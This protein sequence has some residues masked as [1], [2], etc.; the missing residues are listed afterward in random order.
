MS[1]L[2]DQAVRNNALFLGVTETWLH[3]GVLDAEVTYSFPG[4]NILRCDRAGGRQGGGVALYLRDDLTGDIL[5]SY[6]Q[7][8][9]LRGGSV[10]E[11][12]VVKIHQLDTIV[13]VVYRPPDTRCEEF[14]GV[15]QCL[16]RTLSTLPAPSPSILVM[17]DMNFPRSCISWNHSEEEGLLAPLVANHREGETAGGKQ[18]RLQAQQLIDLASKYSLQQEVNTPTHAV[19]ILDLVFSNNCELLT[20]VVSE[21]WDKFSDHNLVIASTTYQHGLDE[22]LHD[23]Q[24][25]CDTGKRYSALNFHKA[26]WDVIRAEIAKVDWKNM[27]ELAETCPTAALAE[28]H[29]KVLAIVEHVVP[30]KSKKSACKPKMERMRRLLWRRLAKIRKKFRSASTIHKVAEY[31]QQMWELETQLSADYQSSTSREE[32]EAVFRI[33]SNSKAFFSFARSRQ[34]IK[35]KIGP[36]MDPI[37]GNPNPSPDF[38]AQVLSQQYNSVFAVPRHAWKVDSDKFKEH[39]KVTEGNTELADINFS[40]ADIEKACAELKGVAAP[41]PDGVPAMLLKSCRKELSK[42]LQVLWRSSLDTG[43]I[44][45]ELLLVQ[46][47]PIHKGG[48]RSIPKNYRPVALTSHLIKV[49]ERVVRRELVSHIERLGLI[50]EGQHG[51]RSMRSTLTQLLAHWDSVLEGLDSGQ[52]VDAVYLDFSKAFDKVETGVLLHK[53]RDGKVLGKVGCWLGAFLNSASRQQAVVVEGRVSALSPVISGVPQGTVLGPVLFLL[54]ISDISKGVSAPTNT[55]SYVDDTRVSRSIVDSQADCSALQQDLAS[56]YSWA[57]EV[58][59]EFNSDKFEVL[60]YWPAGQKPDLQYTSPDGTVIQEK[61]SLK[62]LGVEMASDL[63][64]NLH[65]AKTVTAANQLVGWALRTFRRRSKSVMLTIWKALIQCKLDY[66]SQL[67]SPSDQ[68]N[69]SK[70]E[71][72]ARHFTAK[73]HGLEDMDY[74]ERLQALQLYSQERRRERYMIIFIWK[75]AQGLIQGYQATF[76]SSPRRGRVMVVSPLNKKGPASLRNARESSLKVKG[77]QLF[78]VIPRAMR[79]MI[80][81]T[82]DQFKQML[83][84]WLSTIPDQPT[85]QGRQRAAASN[86]LLDQ[87]PLARTL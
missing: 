16:D 50:P 54:H 14:A 46:I 27:E 35:A 1:F 48:S 52:G 39:F 38:A 5:T 69:I 60:R 72:I 62:D 9:P 68:T 36:F 57:T 45:K 6:A 76:T 13:C 87:V 40:Q 26:P 80:T 70:I 53:L 84:D 32:D 42:P 28:F 19:E 18:D 73:V 4:Y 43:I 41:G 7:T 29:D 67:W 82:P 20:S 47:C 55:T 63:T 64:F 59:M 56:I 83:D 44:P 17:G 34:K 30:K 21:K 25:L 74:W 78:N 2:Y 12:I 66:C 49:F 10:C 22:I 85:I 11:M 81:G 79:D 65:I 33:K 75:V 77:A 23:K 8:H 51:S 3:E 86:S 24:Y 58:N 31:M 37:T 71:S 61:Q 15:L